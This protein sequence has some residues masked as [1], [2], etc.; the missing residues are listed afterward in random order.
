M[1][2]KLQIIQNA[3]EVAGSRLVSVEF[4]KTDGTKRQLT[5]NPRDIQGITGAGVKSRNVD[6]VRVRDFNLGQWRSFNLNR[7][8]SIKVNGTKHI[9][10]QEA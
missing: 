3:K 8:I 7:V 10:T 4:L 6:Q 1:T 9:F 2:S 5:F